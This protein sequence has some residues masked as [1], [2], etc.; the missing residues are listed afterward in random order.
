MKTLIERTAIKLKAGGHTGLYASG[1]CACELCD[2]APCGQEEVGKNGYIND[3][4]PGY[5]HLDP[6]PQHKKFCDWIVTKS[7]EPPTQE[8]WENIEYP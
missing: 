6:R 3:C 8:E 1:E 4:E 7:K 2:L 5:K